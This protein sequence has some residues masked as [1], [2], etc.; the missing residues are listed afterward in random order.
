MIPYGRQ[1][2]SEQDKDAVLSALGNDFLTTGPKIEKF[3]I[4]FAE[5]VG[6]KYAVAVSNGTAALHLSCLAAGLGKGDELITSPLTF[7]ASANCALYC[8]AT[9]K[10]SDI[11]EDGLLDPGRLTFSE[12]TKVIIPVHYGGLPCKMS[13]IKEMA[14]SKGVTVIE[15]ACHALGATYKDSKIG[16]CTYSH[17]TIFSFHPVKHLTTGEGGMITTNSKE[18]YDKLV[19]LRSH[20]IVSDGL[21]NESHGP[22]YREMQML[23]YNYRI[24]D[25]Q[26]ALGLS[27]LSQLSSFIEKRKIIADRYNEAFKD[28]DKIGVVNQKSDRINSY[29]LY[30]IKVPDV[31]MRYDLFIYLKDN[32]ILCQVHYLPVYLNPYYESLGYKKG[33]CVDAEKFYGRI[34]SLPIFPDLTETEQAKVIRLVKGFFS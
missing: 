13:E 34:I 25:I 31:K 33:L 22:W 15:D 20:G 4:A 18:F 24:T 23:G 16:D 3:E 30:V 8:G 21:K 14:D 32:G 27:Q 2:I 17:M 29:H 12:K 10:F 19:A 6:S 26:C 5:F 1:H 7:V 9:P 11:D 28:M